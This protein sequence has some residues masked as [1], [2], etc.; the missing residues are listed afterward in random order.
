MV[1]VIG[2]DRVSHDAEVFGGAGA[3]LG[4]PVALLVLEHGLKAMDVQ[5]PTVSA[6]VPMVLH[7]AAALKLPGP[8]RHR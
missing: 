4:E 5:V 2:V 6:P 8:V 7:F 3:Q 1:G